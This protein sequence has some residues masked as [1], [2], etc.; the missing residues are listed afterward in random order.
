MEERLEL[1]GNNQSRK[2][3]SRNNEI[4]IIP[5][6]LSITVFLFIRSKQVRI[7]LIFLNIICALLLTDCE[8][9]VI[10]GWGAVAMVSTKSIICDKDRDCHGIDEAFKLLL[11]G[12]EC[13]I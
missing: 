11:T 8:I 7:A 1:L 5:L 12:Y 2:K 6:L 9:S 13:S 3:S 10:V 4:L